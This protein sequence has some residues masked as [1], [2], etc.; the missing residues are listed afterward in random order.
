MKI[1]AIFNAIDKEKPYLDLQPAERSINSTIKLAR[2]N[3][4]A[5]PKRMQ[6][7]T[8]LN[9]LLHILTPGRNYH[10]LLTFLTVKLYT[11][12]CT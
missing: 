8:D 9:A 5:Q 7:C 10:V 6:L 4:A 2:A 3:Y 1:L 11:H 12:L